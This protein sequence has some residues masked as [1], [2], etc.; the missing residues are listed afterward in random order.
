MEYKSTNTEEYLIT[1]G[2]AGVAQRISSQEE[3]SEEEGNKED[4]GLFALTRNNIMPCA[5]N[6]Y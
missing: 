4:S 3:S 6:Q 5:H 1:P 2:T